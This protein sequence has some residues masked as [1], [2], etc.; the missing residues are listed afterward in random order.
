MITKLDGK[1]LLEGDLEDGRA[2]GGSSLPGLRLIERASKLQPNDTV[3][4]EY[5]RGKDRKTVRVI[6]DEMPDVMVFR[7][8]G[9]GPRPRGPGGPGDVREFEFRLDGDHPPMLGMGPEMLFERGPGER[10]EIMLGGP[11]ADV[12]LAPLNADL[13]PYFGA[14]AESGV[15]VVSVPK[16][17]T[18]GLKGG[19]V[20]TGI[21][22]RKPSSPAHLLRILRSY[23]AGE[24]VKFDVLRNKQRQSV[25]GKLPERGARMREKLPMGVGPGADR[26]RRIERVRI[27][28]QERS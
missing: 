28:R 5:R 9:P 21:D 4:V 10:V 1:S 3:A 16:E 8:P 25:S 6:T 18:L 20:V 7:T 19:D 12:Q 17:S 15:L 26:E 11:L 23:E 14:D 13:A 22:G 27:Q 2:R 24:T